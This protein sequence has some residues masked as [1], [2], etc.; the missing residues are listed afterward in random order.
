[1]TDIAQIFNCKSGQIPNVILIEGQPGIGKTTLVKEVCIEWA[2]GKLLRSDKLVLLLLL[3]DPNV[4]K[5]T[6]VQ[7]A[8]EYFTDFKSKDI[9]TNIIETN[10]AGIILITDGFDELIGTLRTKSFFT[11]LVEKKVLPK[12]KIVVTSRPTASTCFHHNVDRR[13][14]ILGFDKLVGLNMQMKPCK[15]L[16]LT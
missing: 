11:D 15:S 9:Y 4:Q 13:I 7:Q 3:R 8:I 16:L 2:D 14:E 5:I 6:T 12:A 1:M 10:G